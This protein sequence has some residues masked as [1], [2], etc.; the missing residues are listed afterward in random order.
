MNKLLTAIIVSVLLSLLSCSPIHKA[1][2]R[3]L[4]DIES[5]KRVRSKTDELFRCSNDTTIEF[6]HDSTII[7]N[8]VY[9]RDTLIEQRN[10]T[11]FVNYFD[12]IVKV[13][14]IERTNT[15][16]D[17]RE[18]NKLKDSIAELRLREAAFA[19]RI[20][21]LSSAMIEYKQQRNEYYWILIGVGVVL[22]IVL[23]GWLLSKLKVIKL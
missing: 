3:V 8:S 21:Q 10:D 23:I 11:T 2:R 18:L 12:T 7:Y 14:T 19:G 1:E 17:N 20:Q 15:V 13:R 6:I 22:L 16:T 4:A 5:V 9:K